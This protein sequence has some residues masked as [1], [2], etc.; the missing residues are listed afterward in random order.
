MKRKISLAFIACLLLA[1]VLL[2]SCDRI[3]TNISSSD[4]LLESLKGEKGDKGEPGVGISGAYINSEGHLILKMTDGSEQDAGRLDIIPTICS[5]EPVIDA[6]VPATCISSGLT[7]GLHCSICQAVLKSQ[8]FVPMAP[9]EHIYDNK[10]KLCVCGKLSPNSEGLAYT[11]IENG[12]AYEV[13]IGEA[14]NE[15]IDIPSIY[16]NL[17][18]TRIGDHAFEGRHS[19]KSITIPNGVTS[20]GQQA[21][22]FCNNLTSVTIPSSVTSIGYCAFYGCPLKSIVIPKSVT[23]IGEAAFSGY[24][25]LTIYCEAASQPAG[26]NSYWNSDNLPV[27]WG[28]KPQA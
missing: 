8:I 1:S 24:P 26:W 12:T 14:L 6:A 5:H 17:P 2:I 19:L 10:T 25:D 27:V 18:V 3:G 9:Q 7:E 21:F 4:E 11:L 20:I 16:N 13:S 28:Y 23:S 15:N 22:T